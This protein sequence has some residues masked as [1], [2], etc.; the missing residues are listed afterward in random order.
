MRDAIQ[1]DGVPSTP[2]SVL[3]RVMREKWLAGDHDGAAELA[4]AA[5]PYIHARQSSSKNPADTA[6]EAHRLNDVELATL[7]ALARAGGVG[8][9][10]DPNITG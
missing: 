5:A 7:L 6:K 2:L 10:P 3:L 8:S 4:R 1:D 9:E